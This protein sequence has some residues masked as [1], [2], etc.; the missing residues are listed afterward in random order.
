[1]FY[2]SSFQYGIEGP[3]NSSLLAHRL[4]VPEEFHP[5]LRKRTRNAFE[6]AAVTGWALGLFFEEGLSELYT[7]EEALN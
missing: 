7:R 6:L 4:Q 5:D 1:M 3:D 2:C